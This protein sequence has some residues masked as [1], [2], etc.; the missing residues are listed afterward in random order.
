MKY[1]NYLL[2]SLFFICS[3]TKAQYK[4]DFTDLN[5]IK[6]ENFIV[7][8]FYGW[9]YFNGVLLG[10]LGTTYKIK[11]SNHLGGKVEYLLTENTG[12]GAEVT[13]ANASMNYQ[14]G[15]NNNWYAVGI[16]KLRILGKFNYHFGTTRM[17]DPYMS[18][19][20]GYK[21]TTYYDTGNSSSNISYNLFPVSFKLALGTRIFFNDSF[22]FNA[23]ISLGGPLISAGLSVKI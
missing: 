23:E 12:I 4:S 18:V 19:G 6:Q 16:S 7:E 13:Y 15:M 1:S 8:A 5:C 11:N 22:G 10:S 3:I 9:P 20:M 17:V 2:L 14:S 21:R